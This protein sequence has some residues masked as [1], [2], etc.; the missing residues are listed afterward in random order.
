[1]IVDCHAHVFQDWNTECGHPSRTVHLKYLQK[2]MTRPAARVFRARDGQRADATALFRPGENGWSGLTDVGFRVGSNGQLDFTVA[3]EDYYVQ[4]MPV[5]M[6]QMVAPPELMLAQMTYAGV[7]RCVLQAGGAYGAM[8]DYNAF[9]QHQYPDKFFALMNVDEGGIDQPAVLAEAERAYEKL[10]LRGLYYGLDGLAR[11]DFATGFAAPRFDGFWDRIAR[12]SIPV[13]IEMPSVPSYDEASCIANIAQ[14]DIL[15]AR[16]PSLRFLLVMG[17]PV[18]FF[19]KDGKWDFPDAVARTYRRENLSMEIMYPISWGGVWDYPY[20]EAQALIRDLRD[21][22]GA[23]KLVWGSDMPNV[24]RFCTYTQ[25]VDYV[26]R[27][28]SF[29]TA[30]EKDRIL[31]GNVAE[32]CGFGP[33]A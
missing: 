8:N 25:S 16:Y 33:P 3:G 4:Y 22:V 14:L 10:G 20:P 24:E 7:D 19:A 28:C 17:P 27:H 30:S 21:K 9:A 5:G 18:G 12:W 11:H 6:Q 2:N 23:D 32:I 15:L 1:M 29:L 26:R 31:G 13:F